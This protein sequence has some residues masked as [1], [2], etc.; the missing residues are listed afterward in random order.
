VVPLPSKKERQGGAPEPAPRAEA[1]ASAMFPLRDLHEL[2]AAHGSAMERLAA[3]IRA[4]AAVWNGAV[5]EALTQD[6][7]HCRT[8]AEAAAG[9]SEGGDGD[10]TVVGAACPLTPIPDPGDL[11]FGSL[12]FAR[13]IAALLHP[14]HIP[15]LQG[16][17]DAAAV[18][19]GLISRR[20]IAHC[21]LHMRNSKNK[22]DKAGC[23]HA[24]RYTLV[25]VHEEEYLVLS[26][27][28]RLGNALPIRAVKAAVVKALADSAP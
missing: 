27:D 10:R 7:I 6:E 3:L 17:I 23:I 5:A 4:V 20:A 15:R 18:S 9:A 26:T 16:L 21:W 2:I 13:A 19:T 24:L 28:A 14:T 12:V 1:C 11:D 8:L 25:R 22:E